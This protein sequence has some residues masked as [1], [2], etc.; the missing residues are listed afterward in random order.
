[1]EPKGPT[2]EA[3]PLSERTQRHVLPNYPFTSPLARES[4]LNYVYSLY[5]ASSAFGLTGLTR[6]PLESPPLSSGNDSSHL[7]PLVNVLSMLHVSSMANNY[8][9]THHPDFFSAQSRAHFVDSRL[10]ILLHGGFQ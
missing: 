8:S 4:L 2:E 5:D 3:S 7:L 1:M 9:L 10:R 6:G